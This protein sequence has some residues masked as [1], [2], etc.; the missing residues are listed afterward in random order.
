MLAM[1][2]SNVSFSFRGND[3]VRGAIHTV[4]LKHAID[5]GMTMGIVNAAQLGIYDELDPELRDA[6]EAVVLNKAPGAAEKLIVIASGIK[7]EKTTGE[8]VAAWRSEPLKERIVHSLVKGDDAYVREDMAEALKS[9]PS[10][11]KIVEGPLMDGMGR[12]GELFSSGK[13][14][15]PQVV[16]SARVMKRSVAELMPAIEAEK[17]KSGASHSCTVVIATVKGDVHDIGKNIVSVVLQCNNCKVID[18]GV[19]VPAKT[20]VDAVIENKADILGLSGLITPSLDEMVH[21]AA[22]MERRGVKIPIILGGAATSKL[23]TA[24]KIQPV[25][26]SP[27]VY[28]SDAS[29]TVPVVAALTNPEKRDAFVRKL[30]EEYAQLVSAFSRK[31]AQR[32]QNGTAR[33]PLTDSKR[34]F[35]SSRKPEN[36]SFPRS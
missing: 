30:N 7:Q 24:L 32:S 35:P 28:T 11:M 10:P 36:T 8:T 12:V 19:M 27:I 33:K 18:L 3:V 5:A 2:L 25:S 17:E 14:F 1:I 6:A 22:E 31:T 26:S 13:M 21:V 4:F 15:L 29:S 23:H 20:I 16:K 34:N 9:F